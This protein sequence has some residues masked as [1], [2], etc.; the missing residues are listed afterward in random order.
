LVTIKH[1]AQ[2]LGLAASTVARALSHDE[3]ISPATRAKVAQAALDLG[4]V[5]N[6]A[7]WVW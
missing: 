4:Y 1:I 3:R 6:S 7:W 2:H 5:A